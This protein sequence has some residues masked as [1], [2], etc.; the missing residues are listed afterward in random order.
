MARLAALTAQLRS[1][2]RTGSAPLLAGLS[3]AG[4]LV[5]LAVPPSARVSAICGQVALTDLADPALL[6]ILL[7]S[8][9]GLALDWAVMVLAMMPLLVVQPVSYIRRCSFPSRRNRAV[10]LFSAGYGVCWASA[11]L[12]L[13]PAA[14]VIA[15]GLPQSLGAPAALAAALVWSASPLAQVARNRCH[16]LRRIGAFGTLAD[17][18]CLRQ[19][20]A[21]GSACVAACWPWMIMPM[22]FETGHAAA[23][24][25]VTLLLLAE[26]LVPA[27]TVRWRLPPALETLAGPLLGAALRRSL[28]AA[29]R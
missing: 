24:L 27:G 21:S 28:C 8:P 25:T 26:R 2:L 23:M 16:R 13:V 5:V 4:F 15:A 6:R 11:G 19:G 20:V 12:A 17:V 1:A 3:A 9:W 7:W 29:G 18:D 10:A 22:L 14:V